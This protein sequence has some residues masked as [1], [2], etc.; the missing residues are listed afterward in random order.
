MWSKS[1]ETL[2]PYEGV[3]KV[4][5]DDLLPC[6]FCGGEAFAYD[7]EPHKHVFVDFPDYPGGGFVECVC[8]GACVSGDSKEKAIDT[9]NRRAYNGR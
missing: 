3:H 6:P 2:N 8:C 7:I 5:P 4:A 1:L 9:W